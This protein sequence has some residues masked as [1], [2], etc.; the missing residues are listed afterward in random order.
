LFHSDERFFASSHAEERVAI[1]LVRN[2]IIRVNGD[3]GSKFALGAFPFPLVVG[4]DSE[5]GDVGFDN[6]I[7]K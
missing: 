2:S 4:Q 3:G 5:Q 6:G 1:I 7:I